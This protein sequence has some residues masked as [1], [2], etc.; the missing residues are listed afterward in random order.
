MQSTD[1]EFP[2]AVPCSSAAVAARIA[3][4]L[5]K[6]FL[7]I[8]DVDDP[9]L[10]V[11]READRRALGP[12]GFQ[13]D[14]GVVNHLNGRVELLDLHRNRHRFAAHRD[15]M[16]DVD[17]VL[18]GDDAAD[19][20]RLLPDRR[21][22]LAPVDQNEIVGAAAI[23][24]VSSMNPASRRRY[25]TML[26]SGSWTNMSKS[27]GC[28]SGQVIVTRNSALLSTLPSLASGAIASSAMKNRNAITCSALNSMTA[29]G[30]NGSSCGM[31]S[32]SSIIP[33]LRADLRGS[34]RRGPRSG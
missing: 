5:Q 2:S 6:R 15:K 32:N 8:V 33:P 34:K 19:A 7:V 20:D 24:T 10:G 21:Q 26:P 14:R 11:D 3:Q 31:R 22:D 12:R 23:V 29:N 30:S 16:I 17:G 25:Q 9:T 1:R 4:R 28:W 13:H 27:S 18:A